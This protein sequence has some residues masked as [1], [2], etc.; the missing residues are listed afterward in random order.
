MLA[1]IKLSISFVVCSLPKLMSALFIIF[2]GR[3]E[4]FAFL[5]LFTHL[6]TVRIIWSQPYICRGFTIL[7]RPEKSQSN[8]VL[9]NT[10]T[11]LMFGC[12][13][14]TLNTRAALLLANSAETCQMWF[15][16]SRVDKECGYTVY[17]YE[18][19]KTMPPI[20]TA[21]HLPFLDEYFCDSGIFVTIKSSTVN[22]AW[23]IFLSLRFIWI[24]WT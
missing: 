8:A 24:P 17:I 19:Y 10:V 13:C 3:A 23:T 21:I 16:I 20:Y 5:W 6:H 22:S 14:G 15:H 18:V 2:P 4:W 11:R 9:W 12:L 1:D 7:G